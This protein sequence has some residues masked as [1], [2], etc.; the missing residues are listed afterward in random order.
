MTG[1]LVTWTP[2]EKNNSNGGWGGRSLKQ[3]GSGVLWESGGGGQRW[4]VCP[5][6]P[7]TLGLAQVRLTRRGGRP[8]SR[9]G[10]GGEWAAG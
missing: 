5:E 4:W 7:A 6:A 8:S 3:R 1:H 10:V 2:S 9:P